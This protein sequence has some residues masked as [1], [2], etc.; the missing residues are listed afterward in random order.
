MNETRCS[1]SAHAA[2]LEP[3][4][5]EERREQ[6]AAWAKAFGHP[7]RVQIVEIL[8][9]QEGCMCGD[10]ADQVGSAQSTVS[11]HLKILKE[12]GVIQGTIDGP[13][14][15]YCVNPRV[16]NAMAEQLTGLSRLGRST[17]SGATRH[18]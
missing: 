16:L 2:P 10:I 12:A 18:C 4:S 5:D 6:L 8:L 15:C 14:V 17:A 3:R 13:R 9:A 11:Q 7:S 1:P